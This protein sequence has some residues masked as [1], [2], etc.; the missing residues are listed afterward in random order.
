MT[1]ASSRAST[2]TTSFMPLGVAQ[3]LLRGAAQLPLDAHGRPPLDR[4][5]ALLERVQPPLQADDVG[6]AERRDVDRIGGLV[7]DRRPRE[8]EPAALAAACAAHR[9]G[10]CR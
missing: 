1:S 2:V 6:F 5:Q 8:R 10:A 9:E 7:D 3:K 4:E